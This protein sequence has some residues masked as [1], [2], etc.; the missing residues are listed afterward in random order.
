[1]KILI[2]ML[3]AIMLIACGGEVSQT[4][5]GNNT[6]TNN[7]T[8]SNTDNNAN[9]ECGNSSMFVPPAANNDLC[10]KGPGA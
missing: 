3:I 8:N 1:M 2:N 10:I 9:S 5:N 6:N 4:N 7:D